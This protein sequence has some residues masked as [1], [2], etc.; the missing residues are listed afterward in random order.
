VTVVI[1]NTKK[2]E[3]KGRSTEKNDAKKIN[4]S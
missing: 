3:E 2:K 1:L 4:T